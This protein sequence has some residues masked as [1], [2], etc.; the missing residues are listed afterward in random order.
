MNVGRTCESCTSLVVVE[1]WVCKDTVVSGCRI[2]SSASF[3]GENWIDGRRSRRQ[4]MELSFS[5]YTIISEICPRVVLVGLGRCFA[6][7]SDL[8]VYLLSMSNVTGSCARNALMLE[9]KKTLSPS[10]GTS[11]RSG[12]E[13]KR[14][15]VVR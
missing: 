4:V 8:M 7:R 13:R 6:D 11:G 12:H 10:N 9:R 2:Q 14:T 1:G 3:S 5:V 15:T